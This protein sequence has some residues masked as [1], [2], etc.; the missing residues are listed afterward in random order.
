MLRL[1]FRR[2]SCLRWLHGRSVSPS[3]PW[4]TG[5]REPIAA[6]LRTLIR[7]MASKEPLLGTAKDPSRASEARIQGL[8]PHRSEVHAPALCRETLTKLAAIAHAACANGGHIGRLVNAHPV[9]HRKLSKATSV[10]TSSRSRFW[11]GSITS[12]TWPH[13]HRMGILRPTA[14]RGRRRCPRLHR[15]PR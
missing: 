5:G 10:A 12:T 14:A 11:V 15:V 1:P 7:R 13:D 3:R 2:R 8:C 6:E 4:R 9:R